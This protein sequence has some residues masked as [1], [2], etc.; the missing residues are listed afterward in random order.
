MKLPRTTPGRYVVEAVAK[1]LD[2]LES[3][4][5]DDGL[6]LHE[7]SRKVGLNKSRTFRL[8]YTLAGRGYVERSADGLRYR[9]GVRLFERAA[10]V[11]RNIKD[12]ARPFMLGLHERFN[13]MVNLS[14]I[15]DGQ[16]LYLDILEST[17]AY[18]MV[19]TVG[20]RMPTHTTSMGK[21]TLAFLHA[22]EA[23]SPYASVLARLPR[24][25]LQSL[26][27]E[28]QLIRQRGYAID[29]EEN[30]PGVAC[31]GAPV[32]DSNGQPVAAMSVSGPVQRILCN[33]KKIAE[34]LLAACEGVA[35]NLVP[36]TVGTRAP[37]VSGIRA[38]S[39]HAA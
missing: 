16:L 23:S 12:V 22:D 20:C 4:S 18:R 24:S 2:V 15:D 17:R 11:R 8:L 7:I 30:E 5:S 1:A 36:N 26:R 10:N 32:L 39:G 6:T 27:R 37:R 13:E 33:E 9:L 31:V 25:R 3:F 35:Q 28:L 29:N 21:A 34:A 14:V 19:A 38:R